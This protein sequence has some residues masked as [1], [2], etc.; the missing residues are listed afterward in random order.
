MIFPRIPGRKL[1]VIFPQILVEHING[2]SMIVCANAWYN[3]SC[4]DGNCTG[5]DG[6]ATWLFSSVL[7]RQSNKIPC[8]LFRVFEDHSPSIIGVRVAEEDRG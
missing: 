7:V 8:I 4:R 2:P 6:Q 1:F 3:D 5:P